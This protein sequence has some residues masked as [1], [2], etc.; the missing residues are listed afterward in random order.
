MPHTGLIDA[1]CLNDINIAY[2]RDSEGY[3]STWFD[4]EYVVRDNGVASYNY[5]LPIPESIKDDS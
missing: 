2:Y 4:E 5:F 3:T 1:Y